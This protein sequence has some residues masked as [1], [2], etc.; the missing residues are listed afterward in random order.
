MS[1]LKI[2][3][4]SRISRTVIFV[5]S[6]FIVILWVSNK[7]FDKNWEFKCMRPLTNLD[8]VYNVP[9]EYNNSP[10]VNLKLFNTNYLVIE[11]NQKFKILS[12]N[13][14]YA[15]YDTVEIIKPDAAFSYSNNIYMNFQYSNSVDSIYI[16][17]S[18]STN[19]NIYW[20]QIFYSSVKIQLLNKLSNE[21]EKFRLNTGELVKQD[22]LTDNDTLISQVINYFNENEKS[23]GLAEC[24]TN[25]RILKSICTKY[26]LPCYIITLQGGDS[27][28]TGYDNMIGYPLHVVCEIYSSRFNKWFVLDPSYGTIFT[29]DQVPLNAVEISDNIY[30]KSDI[31]I[32]QDSVLTTHNKMLGKEYF[33]YYRN[34]YFEDDQ[35]P[36]LYNRQLIKYF[37]NH[38]NY[39]ELHY[40]NK[41]PDAMNGR[42]YIS[43]KTVMY[44]LII[45]FYIF[46]ILAILL[47]RL[48]I[49]KIEKE[50]LS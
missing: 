31:N 28:E 34:I 39:R 10:I 25:S 6:I 36:N 37:Y 3:K 17:V 43:C 9:K 30:F 16:V 35:M 20:N 13:K 32:I 49:L 27:H 44:L 4:S 8:E 38:Y 14:D 50:K 15:Y 42:L 12:G 41:I 24:G 29:Q 19:N 48:H 11:G 45:Y 40:S 21:P 33:N 22:L 2:I 23:L 5:S 1:T 18:H 7:L 26:N 47:Y 46:I